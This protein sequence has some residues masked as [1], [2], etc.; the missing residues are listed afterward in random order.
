MRLYGLPQSPVEGVDGAVAL[1]GRDRTLSLYLQLYGRLHRRLA[2]GP[3]LGDDPEA[4]QLEERSGLAGRSSDEER[5]R[6][7]RRLVVVALVLPLFYGGEDRRNVPGLQTQLLGLRPDR[8]LPRELPDRRAPE[9]AHPLGRDVLVGPG[10]PTDAVHVQPALAREGA[11]SHVRTVR[12]GGEVHELG[13]V[14]GGLGELPQTLVVED[15]QAHLELQ[16]G[17]RG[18]EIAVPAPLPDAVYGP[19]HV[20]RS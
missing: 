1:C 11:P 14:V 16:I 20:H 5:Q 12:V 2:V 19:L 9:V 18:D 17:D 3:L 10:I 13:D 8:V 4:L 7:V 6:G 15:L